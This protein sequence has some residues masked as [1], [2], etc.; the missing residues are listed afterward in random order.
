MAE[1]RLCTLQGISYR[2]VSLVHFYMSLDRWQQLEELFHES[3]KLE[4]KDRAGFLEQHAGHDQELKTELESLLDS[5][6]SDADFLC[7]PP[8][9]LHSVV[10]ETFSILKQPYRENSSSASLSTKNQQ[11]SESTLDTSLNKSIVCSDNDAN[12]HA[13]DLLGH[14]PREVVESIH[15]NY[16]YRDIIGSG[17][18][19]IVVRAWNR[20]LERDVAIKLIRR[21]NT[22][23]ITHAL[24]ESRILAGLNSE[25]FVHI[26]D[27][28]NSCGV[29]YLVMEF[30]RG[31]TLAEVLRR[32][33][34]LPQQRAAELARQIAIGLKQAHAAG[35][36]HR[37]I[38]PGNILLTRNDDGTIGWRAKIVDFG[39]ACKTQL[40]DSSS[41]SF[42]LRG[43][44]TYMAPELFVPNNTLQ[45]S[46]DVYA[47]GLTLYEMLVGRT[48]FRG[49]IHMLIQQK[50]AD[51]T[52]P[53]ALDDRI[54]RDLESVCLMAISS[55][56]NN[57]YQTAEEF[58]D[59][60]KR[61]LDGNPTMARPIS[62]WQHAYRWYKRNRFTSA[63][64]LIAAALLM[65]LA[66]GASISS[67]LLWT[68]NREIENKQL[69]IERTLGKQL[70]LANFGLLPG[71]IENFKTA[72]PRPIER[73][74]TLWEE[75]IAPHEKLNLACALAALGENF[76]DEVLEQLDEI[77]TTRANCAAIVYALSSE[78]AKSTRLI[79]S[80]FDSNATSGEKIRLAVLQLELGTTTLAEQLTT[81]SQADLRTEFIHTLPS[82]NANVTNLIKIIG[83]HENQDLAMA[84]LLGLGLVDETEFTSKEISA[85]KSTVTQ[86]QS[87]SRASSG[88]RSA[89]RWLS[90][91]RNWNVTSPQLNSLQLPFEM[92]PI[93]PGTFEMGSSDPAV[94]YGGRTAHP[95]EL[96]I[97]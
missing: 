50:V 42:A 90:E 26:Y 77:S 63:T 32:T 82:W 80:A 40:E 52:P 61:Y 62:D 23:E 74:R 37:D 38:K 19:G 41:G 65:T 17:S 25:Q 36:I 18:S 21:E 35:I 1:K 48:P 64:L 30:V 29:D 55:D 59:D 6:E 11:D 2:E 68:R 46:A 60:L 97:P 33:G 58:A 31:S 71:L 76:Q 47:L 24:I 8:S 94:Q 13:H 4:A 79:E 57:R 92:L 75:T 15:G 49:A 53:R 56:V 22:D 86:I 72:V 45:P 95:V 5:V 96:T 83:D 91:N 89:A 73:L 66:I 51:V 54:D 10:A 81:P 39:L 7:H 16:E 27:M 88:L 85:L 3:L 70:G 43:T 67:S 28:G 20:T 34:A 12:S 93:Q 87:T 84:V 9:A 69:S 14:S 78:T 44:P